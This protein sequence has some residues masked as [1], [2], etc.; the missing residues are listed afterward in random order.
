[1]AL[2]LAAEL[3]Y[4]PTTPREAAE[5]LAAE[6]VISREDYELMRR[7]AGF[8]NIVVHEYTAVDMELVR[9]IVGRREYRR[10]AALAAK[11]LGEARKR[12][13]DP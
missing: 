8:R 2:R 1:M 10:V 3:G 12:G 11:L 9:G 4:A 5:A 6:G 13:L 7:V